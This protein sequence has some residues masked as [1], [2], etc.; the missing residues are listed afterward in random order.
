[1]E[2][3]QKQYGI[4]FF[5]IVLAIVVGLVAYYSYGEGIGAFSLGIIFLGSMFL[6]VYLFRKKQERMFVIFHG[7]MSLGAIVL[8]IYDIMK[9]APYAGIAAIIA[10]VCVFAIMIA[11]Y[12]YTEGRESTNQPGK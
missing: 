12:L 11:I 10:A 7:I 8:G 2:H 9:G 3:H 4:F 1:M 6:N 5:E